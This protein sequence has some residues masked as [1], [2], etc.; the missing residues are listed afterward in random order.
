MHPALFV[1]DGA[2]SSKGGSAACRDKGGGSVLPT[3]RLF[4]LTGRA[5]QSFGEAILP[6][7]KRRGQRKVD[8]VPNPQQDRVRLAKARGEGGICDMGGL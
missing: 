2:A 4:N 3:S 7:G 1:P 8:N 6:D 5:S